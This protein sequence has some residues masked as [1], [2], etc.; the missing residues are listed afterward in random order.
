MSHSGSN[1][2]TSPSALESAAAGSKSHGT[3]ER[4]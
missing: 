3:S 1:F 2:D 4:G